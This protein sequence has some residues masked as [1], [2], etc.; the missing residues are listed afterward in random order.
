MIKSTSITYEH[1]PNR[2][3]TLFLARA[4][5][6]T[7]LAAWLS[8]C[9]ALGA[10]GA[11]ST[12]LDK[13]M[14]V[15]GLRR[16]RAGEGSKPVEV[17]LKIHAGER[18]NTSRNGQPL[19]LVLRVYTLRSPERLKSLAYTRLI[20]PDGDRDALGED[21]VS[22]RELV[23]IPGRSYELAVKVAAEADT[24]GV[25]GLFRAPHADRWKLAFDARRSADSG[26][27]VGAHAC[28]LTAG[29]GTLLTDA[30]ATAS[31]AGGQCNR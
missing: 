31:L 25:A 16:E 8:G 22:V 24:I 10:V 20:P 23:L 3:R 6:A 13:V 27:V 29:A 12:A 1:R 28:A 17:A 4:V 9:A 21:L 2:R 26:I 18:L 14:D 7:A 5:G 15:S 11:A 19:S 30:G